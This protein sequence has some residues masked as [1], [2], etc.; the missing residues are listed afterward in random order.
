[1]TEYLSDY[2]DEH[3][4]VLS[5]MQNKEFCDRIN[6]IAEI[7]DECFKIGN[8]LILCGNGGSAADAQHIAAEF[9]VRFEKKRQALPAIALNT[10][11]SSLTAIGNDFSALEVF[12]RQVEAFGNKGDV[13]IGISTSGNSE[14]VIRAVYKAKEKEM[15][16]I[17]LLGK[18]GGR[19]RGLADTELIVPSNRTS[20]V[21]EM[22]IMVG[23]MICGIVE[24]RV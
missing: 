18:D 13:L 1:M 22:H 7:I 2:M 5:L 19:S 14:N 12:D 8:K 24:E 4:K 16:T 10:N 21:Q 15:K 20:H 17:M 6:K 9:V 3:K 11:S 23:H